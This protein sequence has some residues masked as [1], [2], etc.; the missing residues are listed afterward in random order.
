[1]ILTPKTLLRLIMKNLYARDSTH[2]ETDLEKHI[3]I[4]NYETISEVG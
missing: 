4:R 1:M 3:L 2:I